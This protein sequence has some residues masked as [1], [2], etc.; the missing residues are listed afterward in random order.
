MFTLQALVDTVLKRRPVQSG[1][2]NEDEKINFLERSELAIESFLRAEGEH[3][4]VIL[5]TP[6]AGER[7]WFAFRRHVRVDG[8]T[9]TS[10]RGTDSLIRV[11]S[12]S[13][14]RNSANLIG[15][16]TPEY[17]G[18]YFSGVDFRGA[19]E[20]FRDVENNTLRNNGIP[21]LPIGRFTTQV[22][23]GRA[24]G[25]RDGNDQAN[26]LIKTFTES[27]LETIGSKFYFFLDVEPGHPL[28]R[29]YY[30]GWADAVKN[31]STRVEILPCI[32]LNAL[33]STTSTALNSAI[34][35]GSECHGLWIAAYENRFRINTIPQNI[36]FNA[37]I[38]KPRTNVNAPVLLWQYAGEIG[39][40]PRRD[41]DFNITNPAI[42]SAQ[43]LSRLILPQP[44]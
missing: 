44:R 34:A 10:L 27:Y 18:R 4:E 42:D 22:G 3:I 12:N 28:S 6:I 33:D 24:E 7:Q 2:L 14:V 15:G 26:D 31:I 20:Y 40:F 1:E 23:L 35:A 16:N 19:G 29:A 11:G 21:V 37:N 13:V 5:S 36:E 25:L 9:N 30:S 43:F 17:W 32:Y 41:Y 39:P 38:A 8:E